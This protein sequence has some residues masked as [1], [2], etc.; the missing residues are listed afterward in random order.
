MPTDRRIAMRVFVTGAGGFIGSA[1][2]PELIDAGHEVIGLARSDHAAAALASAGAE[3]YRGSL[4]HLDSLRR[5]AEA[6]DGVIHTAFIHDFSQLEKSGPI[7]LRAIETMGEA[8]AGSGRPLVITSGIGLLKPGQDRTEHDEPDPNG[9][10]SHRVA[11]ELAAKSLASRGVRSAIVRLAPSVHGEGD[12]GFVPALID[13]ARTKGVSGYIG[14]GSNHWAAVHRLDAGR[15]FRL[16]VENAPAGSVLQGVGDEG[17]PTR[18]IAAVIGRHLDVPVASISPD[19][20]AEHF[21]WL[22]G[23]FGADIIASSTLTQQRL[24]WHPQHPGLIA[25]LEDGHYFQPAPAAA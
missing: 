5:G 4:E 10:G 11:S 2:V 16:A 24:D 25:D 12:H 3:A 8:L 14:D 23:F 18:E 1:I 13:I 15:L 19:E 7:D 6:S 22:A 20:A 17:V 21:T 9:S